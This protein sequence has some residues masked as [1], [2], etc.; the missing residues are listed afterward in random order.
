MGK[1]RQTHTTQFPATDHPHALLADQAFGW[2]SPF[3]DRGRDGRMAQDEPIEQAGRWTRFNP[4]NKKTLPDC[5]GVYVI[6]RGRRIIYIG[7][8]TRM[9]HRWSAHCLDACPAMYHMKAAKP[10][11]LFDSLSGKY[12]LSRRLGDWAMREIRLISRIKPKMNTHHTKRGQ[13]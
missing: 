8:S 4:Y 5:A 6:Y 12:S 10:W 9:R 3:A 7:S 2:L 13:R 1:V 11:P